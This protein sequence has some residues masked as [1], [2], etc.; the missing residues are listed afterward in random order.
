MP[1]TQDPL[2]LDM[3]TANN[4]GQELFA[5][6]VSQL[7]Q[8]M[9][10]NGYDALWYQPDGSTCY[11]YRWFWVFHYL[12]SGRDFIVRVN[13]IS[14]A[15][16][17]VEFSHFGARQPTEVEF[18]AAKL[19]RKL[20]YKGSPP[21]VRIESSDDCKTLAPLIGEHFCCILQHL[22]QGGKLPLRGTS[23]LEIAIGKYLSQEDEATWTRWFKPTFLG[24]REF[25][26][27]S[28]DERIAIEIQGDYWHSLE[29][30]DERDEA[31]KNDA[32]DNG[33]SVIWAW[34]SGIKDKFH[35]LLDALARV[36]SGE[37]F[38]EIPRN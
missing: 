24:R 1:L 27:S 5:H 22:E 10:Q 20:E 31:K 33:W 37:S 8:H 21:H 29:N 32:L 18:L 28:I 13:F 12:S 30:S 35:R 36:R 23:H 17:R 6:F 19:F 25:D 9:R 11:R 3:K 14:K 38:V 34:E 2:S 26:L 4:T 16:L 15:T 7:N